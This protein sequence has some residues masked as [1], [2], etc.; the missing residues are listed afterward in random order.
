MISVLMKREY[1]D[2]ELKALILNFIM[3]KGRWGEHYFPIDTM[4]K[5]LG[6][7]VQNNGKNVRK[8]VDELAKDGYLILW[9]RNTTASLNPRAK[10]EIIEFIEKYLVE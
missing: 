6:Q 4:A 7:V 9:K 8:K 5:W 3:R 1:P 2:Q 10:R